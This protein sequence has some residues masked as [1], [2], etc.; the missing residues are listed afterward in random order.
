MSDNVI[1][2]SRRGSTGSG[3]KAHPTEL[4]RRALLR[5]ADA[6]EGGP[7]PWLAHEMRRFA[8]ALPPRDGTR[9]SIERATTRQLADDLGRILTRFPE[10]SPQRAKYAEDVARVERAL[11]RA[12]EIGIRPGRGI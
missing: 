11:A 7:Q 5:A 1:N 3:T 10:G 9:E 4:A 8:D 6:E 12:A 2:L